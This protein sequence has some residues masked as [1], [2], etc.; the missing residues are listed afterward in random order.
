[1]NHIFIKDSMYSDWCFTE[2]DINPM[3]TNGLTTWT[4]FQILSKQCS[5]IEKGQKGPLFNATY[6]SKASAHAI[7]WGELNTDI[8][9]TEN[10]HISTSHSNFVSTNILILD[11]DKVKSEY[12]GEDI[13]TDYIG[14]IMEELVSDDVHYLWWTTPSSTFRSP[15]FR[16]VVELNRNISKDEYK[17]LA[18]RLP[19]CTLIENLDPA[20]FR[21]GQFF[22][23]PYIPT[24]YGTLGSARY[25]PEDQAYYSSFRWHENIGNPLNVDKLPPAPIKDKFEYNT[26]RLKVSESIVREVVEECIKSINEAPSGEG[27]ETTKKEVVKL[28]S[29]YKVPMEIIEEMKFFVTSPTRRKHFEGISKWISEKR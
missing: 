7:T 19:K 3:A 14:S 5:A 24:G 21:L 1:M 17:D 10:G 9:Y 12:N 20:S 15:R 22:I 16:A 8:K 13:T 4:L 11:I 26:M 18:F 27:Y 23:V 29:K 2:V 25:L 28:F 6:P